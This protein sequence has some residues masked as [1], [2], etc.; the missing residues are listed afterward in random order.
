[1]S[2]EP[3]RIQ[4][5]IQA[6]LDGELSAAERAELARLLLADP[7]ARRLHDEF[8]HMDRRLREIPQATPPAGLRPAILAALRLPEAKVVARGTAWPA[9]RLAAAIVGGL[10][11]VGIG[12]RMLD[13]TPTGSDLQGSLG[14]ALPSQAPEAATRLDQA[15]FSGEGVEASAT[16]HREKHGLSLTLEL[17]GST[18]YE[19]IARFDPKATAYS[20][21]PDQPGLSFTDDAVA[22]H[23][24]PG[25]RS[26]TLEFNGNAP[27]LVSILSDGKL[28]GEQ[29]LSVGAS[30][31]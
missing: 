8:K 16:L 7:E 21:D 28:V 19:V 31:N 13:V 30:R 22:V 6:D 15:R 17:G 18:A 3:G 29:E 26:R 10:L 27:I 1:M 14:A 24:E 4:E 2:T 20:G 23:V 25:Q 11:V 9:L 12:Y 5:L